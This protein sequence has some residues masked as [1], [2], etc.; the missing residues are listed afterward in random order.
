MK[1][2][3]PILLCAAIACLGASC[4]DDE[5]DPPGGTDDTDATDTAGDGDGDG[6]G[7]GDGDGDGGLNCEPSQLGDYEYHAEPNPILQNLDLL[8]GDIGANIFAGYSPSGPVSLEQHGLIIRRPKK[9]G[10]LDEWPDEKLPLIVLTH[11][12]QQSGSSYEHL[13]SELVPQGFVVVSMA[14]AQNAIEYR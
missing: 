13:W 3:N 9:P 12:N 1:H 10:T 7:D 14:G 5:T 11:G 2:R 6:T 8:C 4:P